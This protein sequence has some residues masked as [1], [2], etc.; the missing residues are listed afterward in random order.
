MNR[1]FAFI[2]GSWI[3]IIGFFLAIGREVSFRGTKL[4]FGEANVVVGSIF[5][6]FGIAILV[7][8][9]RTKAK[10]FE[11]KS[12]ICPKCKTPFDQK[13]VPDG[14]CPKCEVELEDLEGFYKR[15]PELK[16]SNNKKR[17]NRKNGEIMA[18]DQQS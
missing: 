17:S 5:M 8:A 1:I 11:D 2:T 16:V 7:I 6:M 9:L 13:D 3:A 12:V 15:H 4:E 10:D 18:S 14:R